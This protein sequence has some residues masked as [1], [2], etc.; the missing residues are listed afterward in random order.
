MVHKIP[1]SILQ[2][3]TNFREGRNLH[4]AMQCATVLANIKSEAP[5]ELYSQENLLYKYHYQ[6]KVVNV[7][8]K[9][10]T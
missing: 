3:V 7:D 1:Q 10:T 8:K 5:S 4:C 2:N 6:S 9:T